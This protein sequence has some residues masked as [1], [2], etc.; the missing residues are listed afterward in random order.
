M[1]TLTP[2][3]LERFQKLSNEFEPDIQGPLVSQKQSSNTIALE[4]TNADPNFS[5]KASALAVTHPMSRIMKGD[6]NCGW[7]AVAFGYLENLF[8][9]R[10]TLRVQREL[11]RVKSLSTLLNQVGQQEH[12]YEMFVDATEEVFTKISQAIQNGIQEES[13][14][15]DAFNDEYNSSA[16]ISHFRLLTSAWMKLNP[17]RYQAFLPVPLDEYCATRVETVKSEIDEV[18][19]QALVDGVISGSGFA[20]EILYLDRS[21][22][23]AATLHL[24]TPNQPSV[25]T[26]R[27]LYRPGHYDILYRPEQIVNMAPVMVNY[28]YAVASNY[29]PWDQGALS[30]DLN[31]HLMAIPGLAMDPSFPFAHAPTQIASVP[32][33]TQF[34]VSSPQEVY[35][36]P[37]PI[38]PAAPVIP[39]LSQRKTRPTPPPSTT[40][41]NRSS[42][43]PQIRLNPLVMKPNLRRSFPVTSVKSSPYNQAHFQ[44]QDFEPIHWDPRDSRK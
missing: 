29:P 2:E 17:Q 15:E 8:A 3:E 24:L 4:Y 32:P 22:G 9:L 7:R 12:L 25:A 34:R 20:V 5:A 27:L 1:N 21:E 11:M 42:E 43:G 26:I 23:E 41:S 37:I 18:S 36:S 30:F 35:Q 13:F 39:V 33:D 14:L 38:Q 10:D 16:I 19:L 40:L 44:N 28:Q 31:S 6:G